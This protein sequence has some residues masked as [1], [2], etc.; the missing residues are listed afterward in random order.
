MANSKKNVKTQIEELISDWYWD[1]ASKKYA[2][3]LGTF[4]FSFINYLKDQKMSPRSF[5]KHETNTYF[6]GSF[7]CQ[8]GFNDE[9]DIEDFTDG[10]FYE[11]YYERKVSDSPTAVRGY[12]ATCNK[13]DKY[14]TSNQYKTYLKQI[15]DKLKEEQGEL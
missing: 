3:E 13:L 5:K 4:L 6:I 11:D 2:F 8:Y 7:D 14:I 12:E 15:E 1:E 9:L 10:P